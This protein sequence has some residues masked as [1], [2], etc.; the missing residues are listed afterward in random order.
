MKQPMNLLRTLNS[1]RNICVRPCNV[2]RCKTCEIIIPVKNK[3]KIKDEIIYINKSM[4]CKSKNVIY[5]LICKCKKIY[6]GETKCT[7]RNRNTLHRQHVDHREYG[8]LYVSKHIANCGGEYNIVPVFKFDR[9]GKYT[10]LKMESYFK[11]TLKAE[12]N[13]Q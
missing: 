11:T 7:I 1:E 2:P 9:E 4:S 8:L 3:I 10:R 12:L 6:V 5:I 13:R